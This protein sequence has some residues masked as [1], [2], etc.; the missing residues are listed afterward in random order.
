[1]KT[2]RNAPK[3]KARAIDSGFYR[4]PS[5]C[6][7]RLC[8]SGK[9]PAPGYEGRAIDSKTLLSLVSLQ[10]PASRYAGPGQWK[11]YDPGAPEL[12]EFWISRTR[13]SWHDGEAV[14]GGEVWAL[15][16]VR[17]DPPRPVYPPLPPIPESAE[18]YQRGDYS[19]EKP[20]S[21]G[22]WEWSYTFGQWGRFVTFADGKTV[23]TWPKRPATV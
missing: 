16:L 10:I 5:N 20:A 4:L 17:K 13:L 9:L 6:V 8:R 2:T 23:Y 12:C 11:D 7:A 21:L 18:L 14:E 1:M 3:I 19:H 15:H 22:R